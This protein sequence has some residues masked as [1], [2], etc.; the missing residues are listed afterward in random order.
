[1]KL[2]LHSDAKI[3]FDNKARTLISLIKEVPRQKVVTANEE[4]RFEPGLHIEQ[5]INS[6]DIIG[7]MKIGW[8]NNLGEE[9]GKSFLYE[10]KEYTIRDKNYVELLKVAQNIQRSNSLKN[11]ISVEFVKEELFSWIK[12][13]IK[14]RSQ[15][16]FID[17][18]IKEAE[19]SIKHYEVWIPIPYTAIQ[20]S[21]PLGKITF[22]TVSKEQLEEWFAYHADQ[23][24]NQE[25]I[26]AID[27]YQKKL[28]KDYQG[29][30]AGVYE[31][32]AEPIRAQELAYYH[33]NN[34]L[35]IL[36]LLSPANILPGFTSYAYEYGRKMVR[37]KAYFIVN[38]EEKLFS[39]VSELLDKGSLWK[40]HNDEINM[41][42][43]DAFKNYHDL[44]NLDNPNEFQSKLLEALLIYSKNTL[45]RDLYDKILYIL[46][47]L[48]SI[49]LKN[50]TEPIQQSVGDRMAF[51]IG[52]NI[53]ERK[54]IVQTL[55]EVYSIRSKFI[56]HGVQGIENQE[57]IGRFMNYA[58]STFDSLVR[59][60]NQFKTKEDC[61]TALEHIK[62]S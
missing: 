21:F 34:S 62:Y 1:M 24:N 3:N 61:I 4:E 45:R 36:R 47:A 11:I 49:L 43:S 57:V 25:K 20:A 48:E 14:D 2:E 8:A 22:K 32:D 13:S 53:I 51:A 23:A 33:V 38:K 52:K 17:Q 35:G 37:S 31:C 59:H 46:V 55:K 58:F 7:E 42:K 5:T 40:L 19:S 30:A 56:H 6:K 54:N 41:I 39:D 18:L 16:S 27:E 9:I 15:T 44:L 60:L 10:N 29:Y 12:K 50:D 28:K 26:K